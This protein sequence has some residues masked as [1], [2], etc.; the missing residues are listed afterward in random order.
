MRV[1]T[2]ENEVLALSIDERGVIISLKNKV[3]GNEYISVENCSAWK[4]IFKNDICL[5]NP[6][7]SEGQRCEV[8][9]DA[10]SIQVEYSQLLYEDRLLDIHLSYSVKF[11]DESKDE[12]RWSIELEND[13]DIEIVEIWFPLISGFRSL[14]GDPSQDLLIW[15]HL[16]GG[17][18]TKDPLNAL[19]TEK[20][21]NGN[22]IDPH[23]MR[24]LY[25]GV[26]SMSW[27]D[28][29]NEQE[30]LYLAS[31]DRT[32]QSTC[33]NVMKHFEKETFA[34][35]KLKVQKFPFEDEEYL[36][37][38]LVKYPFIGRGENWKANCY[39]I[40][41]HQGDWHI[42]SQKYRAWA[43]TWMRKAEPPAWIAEDLVGWQ[44]IILKSQYGE[45]FW[46]Y[47]DIPGLFA[48]MKEAGITTF[49]V[50]GW[51]TGGMDNR[52]PE[53]ELDPLLGGEEEFKR[54]IEK[55]KEMGGRVILYT[56]GRLLDLGT[57]FYRRI[58]HH[59][60]AK[61]LW[62]NEYHEFY[63]FSH[64]GTILTESNGKEFAIACPSNPE[65][66]G[67]LLNQVELVKRLGASG[68]LFDQLGGTKP[69]LCFDSSHPHE[70]PS[71]AFGPNIVRNWEKIREAVKKPDPEFG[72]ITE[73]TTD[74]Y[75]QQ[76]DIVHGYGYGR[77]YDSSPEI[78]RYTFPERIISCR[79]IEVGDYEE[80]N[81]AFVYGLRFD[82]AIYALSSS[83]SEDPE[84][85]KYIK[86]I[87]D[88]RRKYKNLLMKGTFVDEDGFEINDDRLLAKGY[89]ASEQM[90]ILIWNPT[91]E[92]IEFEIDSPG[93]VQGKMVKVEGESD[94]ISGE[95]WLEANEIAM[96]LL[97][98]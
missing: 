59:I 58:G 43:D 12:L 90:A 47:S 17:K 52:Y 54:A 83:L 84:L 72:V 77:R 86:A 26:A 28:I 38:S 55:V 46:R 23:K 57:E 34:S 16:A 8:K 53:Y 10:R 41:L 69:Y 82:I 71:L 44:I 63:P 14:S 2:L 11:S 45:I 62:G 91:T 92:G 6:I 30:G 66:L 67:V 4:L 88:I 73:L 32:L 78:F 95:Y 29:C 87:A 37:L 93:Y 76:V 7:F 49:F 9:A 79:Q 81:F 35:N 22:V 89:K 13:E 33:L 68:M 40:S 56:Q 15:P 97:D 42:A 94:D 5:E 74:V 48:E 80:V 70:K 36:S 27:F 51:H 60:S 21:W 98:N 65:W 24:M 96:I 50:W 18:K 25:P 3:T 75:T 20:S 64:H 39:V 19:G 1:Y 61:C 85:A 31:Y